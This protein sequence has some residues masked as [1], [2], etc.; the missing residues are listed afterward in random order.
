MCGVPRVTGEM[1]WIWDN[2]REA[3]IRPNRTADAKGAGARA[4][5]R[6]CGFGFYGVPF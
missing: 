6:Y 1:P 3:A 4:G 2:P 5:E